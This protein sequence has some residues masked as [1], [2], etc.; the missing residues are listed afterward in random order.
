MC[1]CDR[2]PAPII[3]MRTLSFFADEK[4]LMELLM[5]NAAP[6]SAVVRIKFLLLNVCDIFG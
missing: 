2:K 4:A 6:V 5:V 3:P 1:S